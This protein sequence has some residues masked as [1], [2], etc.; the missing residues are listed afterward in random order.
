[1]PEATTWPMQ[2]GRTPLQ[3]AAELGLHA[4]SSALILQGRLADTLRKTR[5]LPGL[6]TALGTALVGTSRP[7]HVEA[8]AAS[9]R[10]QDDVGSRRDASPHRSR[11]RPPPRLR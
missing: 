8:N 9:F 3:A 6:G 7:A 4:M 5:T 10:H 2:R 1:M 11:Q